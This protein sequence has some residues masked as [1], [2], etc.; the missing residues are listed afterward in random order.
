[1]TS[2]QRQSYIE[3]IAQTTYKQ[4]ERKWSPT[5]LFCYK[6]GKN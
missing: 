2:I 5:F 6:E 3:R 4:K 1:M